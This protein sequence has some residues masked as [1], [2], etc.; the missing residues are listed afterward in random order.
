MPLAIVYATG[1]WLGATWLDI[2]AMASVHGTLNVAG[3]AVPA[4][5]ALTEEA[6]IARQVAPA[7]V[8]PPPSPGRRW[9]IGLATG[10]VMGVGLL[11]GGPLIG[12]LGVA[13]VVALA[14]TPPRLA[15][16]AGFWLGFGVGWLALFASAQARCGV[17]CVAPDPTPWLVAGFVGLAFGAGLTFAA[18]PGRITLGRWWPVTGVRSSAGR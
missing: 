6:R 15:G 2:P 4:A 18:R 11:I 7:V 9:A 8:A 5:I 3:F 12:V 13:A 14:A 1:A 10:L 16:M 17:D